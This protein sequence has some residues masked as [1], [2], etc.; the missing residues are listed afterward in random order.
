[1]IPSSSFGPSTDPNGKRKQLQLLLAAL[2]HQ[3][4][5]DVCLKTLSDLFEVLRDENPGDGIT[6]ALYHACGHKDILSIASQ[7]SNCNGN[8][9]WKEQQQL[10]VVVEAFFVLT[11]LMCPSRAKRVGFQ[12]HHHHLLLVS[13]KCLNTAQIAMAAIQ[14]QQHSSPPPPPP[15]PPP[16]PQ[17]PK[18]AYW[19]LA[20]IYGIMEIYSLPEL[21]Q[22]Q[23]NNDDDDSSSKSI[24]ET[25][26]QTIRAHPDHS[27]ILRLGCQILKKAASLAVTT[28]TNQKPT[29]TNDSQ[30]SKPPLGWS[31]DSIMKNPFRASTTTTTTKTIAAKTSSFFAIFK[32]EPEDSESS[33]TTHDDDKISTTRSRFL[34]VG[35]ISA[36]AAVMERYDNHDKDHF[37]GA[38]AWDALQAILAL[39]QE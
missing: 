13:L 21:F 36:L 27:K 31:M 14:R 33:N 19:A 3:Q 16:Q 30:K 15:P 12:D 38:M 17:Q 24:M 8:Q 6:L 11:I 34:Q 26:V 37:T 7:N 10:A 20:V 22:H 29:P 2:Q 35:A 18:I 39:P 32:R 28:T 23:N 9:D 1:M 4:S 5:D 25:T